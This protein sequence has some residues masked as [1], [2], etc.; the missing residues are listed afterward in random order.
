MATYTF[1]DN[2]AFLTMTRNTASMELKKD[3]IT[4]YSSGVIV[5]LRYQDRENKNARYSYD[6]PYTDI[7]SPT[8]TDADDA[9]DQILA[10]LIPSTGAPSYTAAN[11]GTFGASL[12]AAVPNDTDVVITVDSTTAKKITWT[13]VKAFLKTYFDTIY[14]T[15]AAVATQISTALSGYLTSATAAATYQPL[16]S[17]LTTIAGLT[18]TSDN[19]IQAKSGAWASRTIAQVKTDLGIPAINPYSKSTADQV[20]AAPAVLIDITNVGI[21]IAA[22]QNLYIRVLLHVGC[23]ANNG[24][25]WGVTIPTGA[26]MKLFHTG[27]SN[28]NISEAAPQWLATSG[29]EGATTNAIVNANMKTIMEGWVYNGA[30]AGTIQVQGRT[31]NAANTLTI[32]TGSMIVGLVI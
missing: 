11:F 3:Y 19:F 24:T 1:T 21:A 27:T 32:Y 7:S 14:T 20:T 22:N 26:T 2:G 12:G 23:S 28:A 6:I 31:A 8:F 10:W 9:R 17:D 5:Y 15:T 13:N 30:N 25:R 18:A 4:V 16:D 29:V